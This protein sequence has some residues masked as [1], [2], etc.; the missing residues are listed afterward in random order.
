M[1]GEVSLVAG[2]DPH[3][4]YSYPSTYCTRGNIRFPIDIIAIEHTGQFLHS[5]VHK[6]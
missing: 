4:L 3:L 5:D 1:G 6:S 2:E